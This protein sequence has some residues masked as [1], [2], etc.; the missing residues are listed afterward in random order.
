M[1]ELSGEKY[2]FLSS[3]D[4]EKIEKIFAEK[5]T[6]LTIVFS[7]VALYGFTDMATFFRL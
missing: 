1:K 6:Q 4:L 2:T 7:S 5:T 3:D